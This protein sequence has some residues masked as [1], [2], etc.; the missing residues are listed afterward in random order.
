MFV[1]VCACK[2]RMCVFDIVVPFLEDPY[3]DPN[4]LRQLPGILNKH[5]FGPLISFHQ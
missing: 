2:V 3:R 5:C 1:R 4:G